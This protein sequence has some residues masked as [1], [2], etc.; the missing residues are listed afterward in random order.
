MNSHLK[1]I[2]SHFEITIL[3]FLA[4]LG[5]EVVTTLT[6]EWDNSIPI[7]IFLSAYVALREL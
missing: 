3:S 4:K 2:F 6:R 5:E 1:T 7:L